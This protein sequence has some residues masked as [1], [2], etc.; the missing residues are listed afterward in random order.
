[1]ATDKTAPPLLA[2]SLA[3]MPVAA[4]LALAPRKTTVA[5]SPLL[6]LFALGP[7]SPRARYYLRCVAFLGGLAACSVWGV[8]SALVVAVLRPS[9][10]RN[11]QWLVARSF[12]RLVGP[13]VGIEFVIE[14][15]E[16]LAKANQ[17]IPHV[18]IGNHQS[19]ARPLLSRPRPTCSCESSAD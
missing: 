10:R 1:M 12:Y 8:V 2:L 5:L 7:F 17:G 13:V 16:H 6:V 18:L 3:F 9:W 4:S 11:I 19:M 14:G 15:E